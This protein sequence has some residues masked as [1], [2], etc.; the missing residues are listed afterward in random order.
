M[1]TAGE[2]GEFGVIARIGARLGAPPPPAG[3][4]DDAAV[5][6][7][8]DGRVVVTTDLLAEGVHF[9]WDWSSPYDVG[10]KAAAANLA[11]IAA[12]GAVPTALLVGIALP[13]STGTQV[14]DGLADGL[15]DE[16]A[17]VGAAIVG[18]DTIASGDRLTLA[19]TALGD[20][21]GRAPVTRAASA[22][23]VLVLAGRV[24]WSAAGLALLRAGAAMS[25]LEDLFAAHRRPQPPYAMGPAL[26]KAGALAMCDVSDGLIADVRH[27]TDACGG[28]AEIDPELLDL[29]PLLV[30]AGDRLGCPPLEWMLTG[31][32]DHALVAV[33]PEG[34]H[35]PGVRV[36]GR[37]DPTPAGHREPTS[38]ATGGVRVRGRSAG[39]GAGGHAHFS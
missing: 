17:L 3:P 15:R 35:L 11:D 37:L 34:V 19:I 26:A 5:V 10:R 24:G 8:P 7:T 25:G 6:G 30:A 23:G 22:P 32:E 33:L 39:V 9:R 13:A 18:G 29:D 2:L 4:G 1:S 38:G 21:Q 20:L 14:L 28:H 27:L 16:C 31:G 12:M 36:I